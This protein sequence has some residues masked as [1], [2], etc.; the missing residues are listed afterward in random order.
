MTER[1]AAI[2]RFQEQERQIRQQRVV[3]QQSPLTVGT[4]ATIPVFINDTFIQ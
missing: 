2:Q 4:M 1:Y 3:Q